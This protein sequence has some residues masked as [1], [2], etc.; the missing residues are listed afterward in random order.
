V[1]INRGDVYWIEFPSGRR[2]AAVLTRDSA[3]P[4]LNVVIVAPASRTIRGIPTEV[5]LGQVDGMP[6]DCALGLDNL[7]TVPKSMLKK[8]ITTLSASRL[9]EACEALE[10]ALGCS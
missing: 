8:R 7:R 4:L 6:S 3:L 1:K 9:D 5:R 2:P 10:Y